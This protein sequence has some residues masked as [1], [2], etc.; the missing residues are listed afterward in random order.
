MVVLCKAC[1]C[2]ISILMKK[3][4]LAG[5]TCMCMSMQRWDASLVKQMS[6]PRQAILSLPFIFCS[7]GPDS[8]GQKIKGPAPCQPFF[9]KGHYE[10]LGRSNPSSRNWEYLSFEEW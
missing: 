3:M 1:T 5:N 8:T 7:R 10:H 2:M 9:I 6:V 4:S